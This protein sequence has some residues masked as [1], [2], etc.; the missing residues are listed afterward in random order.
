MP[1]EGQEIR[2][3]SLSEFAVARVTD[4]SLTRDALSDTSRSAPRPRAVI[5]RIPVWGNT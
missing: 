3:A 2:K 4:S 5:P 1:G